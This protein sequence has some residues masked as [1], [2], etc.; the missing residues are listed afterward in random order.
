M[1]MYFHARYPQKRTCMKAQTN[2]QV[3][4]VHDSIEEMFLIAFQHL[5]KIYKFCFHIS[6]NIGSQSI[7]SQKKQ[8]TLQR[9]QNDTAGHDSL[10]LC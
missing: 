10:H 2:S 4:G 7:A 1:G 6:R 8:L 3:E 9:Y 5:A